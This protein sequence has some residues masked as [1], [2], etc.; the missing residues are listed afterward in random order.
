MHQKSLVMNKKKSL[1]NVFS[2]RHV[3]ASA[4]HNVAY[5]RSEVVFQK[6]L[7]CGSSMKKQHEVWFTHKP[8]HVMHMHMCLLLYHTLR[9]AGATLFCAVITSEEWRQCALAHN[10]HQQCYFYSNTNEAYAHGC[11]SKAKQ[12]IDTRTFVCRG[13]S[14][15]FSICSSSVFRQIIAAVGE[16]MHTSVVLTLFW[17]Y[18]GP[19]TITLLLTTFLNS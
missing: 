10:K 8:W 3:V 5:Y 12:G 13:I 2:A 18:F 4:T 1:Q 7:C 16:R 15:L 14:G 19:H 17:T 6:R 11:R 9:R